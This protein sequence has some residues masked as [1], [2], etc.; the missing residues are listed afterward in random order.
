MRNKGSYHLPEIWYAPL[1]SP[2]SAPSHPSPFCV[3]QEQDS[4]HQ[5]S[6]ELNFEFSLRDRSLIIA[7][8]SN[9]LPGFRNRLL[10][11]FKRFCVNFEMIF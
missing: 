10:K 9:N 4:K 8:N 11:V 7:A 1:R 3:H 2:E 6:L 5:G